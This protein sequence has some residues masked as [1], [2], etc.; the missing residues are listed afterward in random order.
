MKNIILTLTLLGIFAGCKKKEQKHQYQVTYTFESAQVPYTIQTWTQSTSFSW[1]V[2][3]GTFTRTE[4][5]EDRPPAGFQG[6]ISAPG[7]GYKRVTI[8]VD[9]VSSTCTDTLYTNLSC[10]GF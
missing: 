7:V 8:I 4:V 10:Q 9:G 1:T 2:Q 5:H 6:S 3:S